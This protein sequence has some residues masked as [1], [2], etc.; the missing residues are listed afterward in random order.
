MT[1]GGSTLALLTSMASLRMTSPSSWTPPGSVVGQPLEPGNADMVGVA[2]LLVGAVDWI[3]EGWSYPPLN[4]TAEAAG[5][6]IQ[7]LAQCGWR[8]Q[9]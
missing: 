4:D 7:A 6:V 3:S 9:P 8:L 1:S 2:V 5:R